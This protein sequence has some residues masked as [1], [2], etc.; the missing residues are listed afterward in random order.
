M[1]TKQ[2]Q[3]L[4]KVQARTRKIG[5]LAKKIVKSEIPDNMDIWRKMIQ[6]NDEKQILKAIFAQTKNIEV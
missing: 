2:N 1:K 4:I 6:S 5:L 3:N